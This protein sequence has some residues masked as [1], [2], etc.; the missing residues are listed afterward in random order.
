M[1]STDAAERFRQAPFLV[2]L[3]A[4]ARLALL[5]VLQEHRAESGDVLL[6][7]GQANDRIYF[8]IEG[9]VSIL[10]TSADGR[11]EHLLDLPSPTAFGETAYFQRRPQMVTVQAAMPVRYLTLDREAHER[12]RRANPSASEQLS[13][14][15]IRV[16]AGHFELIDQ[17][18]AELLSR[19]PDPQVDSTE[20]DR[21]RARL[22]GESKL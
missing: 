1:V 13:A 2:D 17:R 19:Q 18:V 6:T 14:A 8:L 5:E 3:D 11:A 22:F 9:T 16:L 10:R 15:A 20:W 21:F 12:L 7:Q 4:D